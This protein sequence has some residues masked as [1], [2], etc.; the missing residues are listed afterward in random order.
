M[1]G[2]RML[3][4]RFIKGALGLAL[5]AAAVVFFAAGGTA[6]ALDVEA[7][8]KGLKST[9][10]KKISGSNK[11]RLK[12][13]IESEKKAKGRLEKR[14][15][16]TRAEAQCRKKLRKNLSY[17]MLETCIASKERPKAK[18]KPVRDAETVMPPGVV[19]PEQQKQQKIYL[20]KEPP[21]EQKRSLRKGPPLGQKR[22]QQRDMRKGSQRGQQRDLR[23]GP[24]RG[25]QRDLR[26]GP[27]RGP[28]KSP[29]RKRPK[30]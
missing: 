12:Q 21:P 19:P 9:Y 18:K 10:C 11:V 28:R 6:W 8:L 22:G 14:R 15:E 13:C 5:A 4:K 1:E 16:G 7:E 20:R 23:K 29:Q 26:K 2:E 24:Q 3:V 17:M 27:Q 30:R 25:Q